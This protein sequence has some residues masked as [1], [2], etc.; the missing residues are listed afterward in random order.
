MPTCNN[1]GRIIE[2]DIDYD[3][4]PHCQMGIIHSSLLDKVMDMGDGF[5]AF[6]TNLPP[7]GEYNSDLEDVEGLRLLEK[8]NLQEA[9]NFYDKA[10]TKSSNN[11]RLWNNF[12]VGLNAYKN[13][14][15]SLKSFEKCLEIDSEYEIGLY[16]IGVVYKECNLNNKAIEYY[17]K[18]L[19]LNPGFIEA[20]FAKSL[21]LEEIGDFSALGTTLAVA[22]L[23]ENLQKTQ[24]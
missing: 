1:C 16:N 11:I 5:V 22:S 8:M 13:R 7:F 9:L 6:S 21:A 23:K 4:C 17:D 15:Y 3:K 2:L 18:A 14:K 20:K 19:T 24:N 12:G 10:I